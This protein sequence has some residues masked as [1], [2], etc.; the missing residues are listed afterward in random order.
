MCAALLNRGAIATALAARDDE[1]ALLVCAGSAGSLSFEDLLCA[2]AIVDALQQIE[3]HLLITDAARVALTSG[4]R[5]GAA[6]RPPWPQ[7]RTQK[8]S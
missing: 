4:N 2:G 5:T 8:R 1:E 7:V 3:R 6:S